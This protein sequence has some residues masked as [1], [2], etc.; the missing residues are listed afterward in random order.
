MREVDSR[1]FAYW[2]AKFNKDPVGGLRGDIQ[3]A[4]IARELD[5]L[6]QLEC[7][8]RYKAKPLTAFMPLVKATPR[9]QTP[10]EMLAMFQMITG[11]SP[12]KRGKDAGEDRQGQRRDNR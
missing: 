10:E 6:V 12:D 1:E 2:K 9:S 8:N 3:A 5:K 7:E 4:I 11:S